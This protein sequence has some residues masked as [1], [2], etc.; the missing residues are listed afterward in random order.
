MGRYGVLHRTILHSKGIFSQVNDEIVVRIQ[1]RRASKAHPDPMV[2]ASNLWFFAKV[3]IS[4][5]RRE[6]L[7][8]RGLYKYVVSIP[9][10]K[11]G[12]S[13]S[14]PLLMKIIRSAHQGSRLERYGLIALS[15]KLHE[16]SSNDQKLFKFL[17]AGVHESRPNSAMEFIFL[18]KFAETFLSSEF[19][20]LCHASQ[21]HTPKRSMLRKSVVNEIKARIASTT[22]S[23]QVVERAVPVAPN[24]TYAYG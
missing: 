10:R 1:I 19:Q 15:I 2:C 11:N 8:T 12:D 16:I 9:D 7:F 21:G 18:K 20:N 5:S 6:K 14:F 24:S 3:A 22:E 23:S 17:A 13:V 4:G